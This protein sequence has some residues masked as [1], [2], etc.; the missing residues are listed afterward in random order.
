MDR[1]ITRG[2]ARIVNTEGMSSLS[3]HTKTRFQAVRLVPRTS[4]IQQL[5]HQDKMKCATVVKQWALGGDT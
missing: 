3:H 5:L 4:V 1:L 2:I